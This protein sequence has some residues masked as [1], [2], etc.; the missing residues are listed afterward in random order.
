MENWARYAPMCLLEER[1]GRK[2]QQGGGVADETGGFKDNRVG[3]H[4]Y[5]VCLGQRINDGEGVQQKC[6]AKALQGGQ[7][8]HR[9]GGMPDQKAA[10]REPRSLQ[11]SQMSEWV[12]RLD[13]GKFVAGSPLG[14]VN[15]AG[16]TPHRHQGAGR[17]CV[18]SAARA[19]LARACATNACCCSM[20]CCCISS[21]CELYCACGCS[22]GAYCGCGA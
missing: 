4:R 3:Y 22:G 1:N 5:V 2:E 13:N 7:A 15:I 14:L 10:R 18:P 8:V 20:S 21:I 19:A 16:R 9:R 12:A 17:G 6:R 11:S